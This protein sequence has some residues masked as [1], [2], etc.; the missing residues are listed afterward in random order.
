MRGSSYVVF[1]GAADTGAT[2]NL[3]TLDGTNGYRLDGEVNTDTSG[4]S[5]SSAGDVNG[6]GYDDL[7]IGAR[8]ADPNE[9]F[10][11]SSYVVFG[12]AATTGAIVN[13][14][15]LDGTN[16]FRLD[17]EQAQQS[18]KS[19]SSAGD[20]NGDG[21][22]DLIISASAA[23][24]NGLN[25]GSSYV[26]FGGAANMGATVN[27]S[28]LDGTNGFRLDGGELG[29]V[30][31]Y[32]V[33]S[34]GDVNGDGYDDLI[35]GAVGTDPNGNNSGSSYVVFGSG[36]AFASTVD[37]STLDGTTGFRLDGELAYDQS[38]YSVS[39]AGDVN[40]DGYDDLI[41]G[42]N[43]AD[44]NGSYSGSSY[45]VF[46]TGSAF[47]ATVDLSSLDG[48]TGFRL[49]GE[50][51]TDTSG[52]SVSSAGDINGDGYDDL[53]I[54]ANFADPNDIFSGSSY[55]VFGSDMAFATTVNLSTL[56]GTN[57]FRLDGVAAQDQSGYS[58]S[59]AGDVNGD[60]YD[61]LI[62]GAPYADPNDST[63]GS[64]GSSYVVYGGAKWGTYAQVA[65]VGDDTVTGTAG[66]ETL[67]GGEGNDTLSGLA[68]ND[69]LKG[70]SGTDS[71]DGGAGADDLYGGGNLDTF[72]LEA[73][74]SVLSFG[75]TGDAGTVTGYDTIHD[76][77]TGNGTS[78]SETLNTVGTATVVADTTGT[79]GTD[80]T[81]T[82][83]G[84]AIKSHAI[85]N[86]V[87]SFDDAD[88]FAGVLEIST[89]SEVAAALDYLQNNDL[90]DA[91]ATVTFDVG[92][93]AFVFTQGD[94][95]GDDAQD[96]VVRLEGTQIDSLITTNGTGEFDL[97]IV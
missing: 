39:S 1:G 63:S 89:N 18:G 30:S 36:S 19:V 27:L 69:I 44:F 67:I 34:A 77:A 55:V 43:G 70:G 57:G 52:F 35:I 16:G 61:D 53:V 13:L 91:G 25:S 80:S 14:S 3:S 54:G 90:G 11:G 15:S 75:G 95:A 56:D 38:G 88:T 74:D 17:G 94:D 26:V 6:D 84:T 23:G 92:S 87:I 28:S 85:A 64:S 97:Y 86:G 12:G 73:G 8:F 82:I 68:D 5:V 21:Y 10:S 24:Y 47:A 2:V 71:L 20:V 41:I 93:D 29:A 49:D 42:A 76:F 22:D 58:V 31:G 4:Y 9:S 62:I 37:L 50:A 51:D 7:V 40:G 33:S 32:S 65:T 66:A 46:G 59:S 96:V 79:D 78:N 48:T 81:L 60:G 72:I 45:V 83:G